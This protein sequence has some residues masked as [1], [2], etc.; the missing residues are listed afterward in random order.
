MAPR[1]I[2]SEEEINWL[3]DGELS[4]AQKA[5][6]QARLALQ[7]D[8][9]ARVFGDLRRM[10][11]LRAAQPQRLLAPRASLVAA[12]RLERVLGRH[13]MFARLRAPLM[14]ASLV[15]FGWIANNVTE[16]WRESGQTVDESFILAAREALRVAQLDLG[17]AKAAEP[18]RNKMGRLEAAIDIDL[19]ELPSTWEV[20]D[21]QVQPWNGRQSVVVSAL[22]PGLGRVTLVA[23]PMNGEDAIPPTAAEDGRMPTIYWQSGGTA[24]ALMGP[25]TPERL[26]REA[27]GI[28]VASRRNAASRF[29]S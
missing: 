7:P 18:T 1:S 25:A 13:R 23:A 15:A 5:D 22:A 29:R 21:I 16:P 27:K 28:E 2:V 17:V 12:R 20:R 24:Y 8:L 10:E 6:L 3:L 14:A 9:A 26:E 4:A 11:A 19:P